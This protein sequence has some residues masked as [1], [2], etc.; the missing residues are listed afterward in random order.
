MFNAAAAGG[1]PLDI[2][3]NTVAET[4]NFHVLKQ[5]ARLENFQPHM[6]LRGK[7][8]LLEAILPDGTV[9]TISYA[10]NFNFNWMNN[11][12]YAEDA[13]PVFPKG[14]IIHV[15]AWHDNTT[16]KASNPD[17]NQWVGWGD[18]TVDEMAH[19]W[20]NVTYISDDDYTAWA[21]TH[22]PKKS[23]NPLDFLSGNN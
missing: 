10:N 3:P 21:S 19:A 12:I 20:V 13:A 14:T 4:E 18:R 11:Y 2:P 8:M 17:P 15:K 16:A 7:A 6:H 22:K 9:Q 1:T 5:A 23:M